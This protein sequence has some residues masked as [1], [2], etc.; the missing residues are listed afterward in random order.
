MASV[1]RRTL[2][3][4][5]EGVSLSALPCGPGELACFQEQIERLRCQLERLGDRDAALALTGDAVR[6]IEG[7]GALAERCLAQEKEETN[8][9]IRMLAEAFLEVSGVTGEK[10]EQLRKITAEFADAGDQNDVINADVISVGVINARLQACLRD[11][12]EEVAAQKAAAAARNEGGRPFGI[13]QIAAEDSVPA[14]IDTATGLP[15]L[16]SAIHA[17]RSFGRRQGGRVSSSCFRGRANG[18]Y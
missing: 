17:I 10:R 2:S 14:D 11:I 18:N 9:A 16:K 13:S 8:E 7:Y 4:I 5:L 12:C 15:G 3:V 6:C 1:F